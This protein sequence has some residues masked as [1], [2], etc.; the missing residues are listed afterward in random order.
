MTYLAYLLVTFG[1]LSISLPRNALKGTWRIQT[2]IADGDTLYHNDDM[3]YTARFYSSRLFDKE[4]SVNAQSYF[5]NCI[6]STFFAFK[7]ALLT[8]NKE[9]YNQTLIK[10]CWHQIETESVQK[11]KYFM[12]N[13]SITLH[14]LSGKPL[15]TVIYNSKMQTLFFSNERLSYSIY[16]KRSK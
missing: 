14:E 6:K 5:N 3:R 16:Y 10:P 2:V 13:D 15:A 8:F 4:Q 11:G 1:M 12:Q 7:N 9:N